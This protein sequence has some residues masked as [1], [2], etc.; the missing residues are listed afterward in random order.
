MASSPAVRCVWWDHARVAPDSSSSPLF[1]ASSPL[2]IEALL[3]NVGKHLAL[4]LYALSPTFNASS[5]TLTIIMTT[6][7]S[8]VSIAQ[9]HTAF[10]HA[11]DPG[12]LTTCTPSQRDELFKTGLLVRDPFD[13]SRFLETPFPSLDRGPQLDGPTPNASS[14]VDSSPCEAR[15][16]GLHLLSIPSPAALG[17]PSSVPSWSGALVGADL[18]F[19]PT[20]TPSC[21]VAAL[22][23]LVG[24]GCL[25][26]R[27]VSVVATDGEVTVVLEH[28]GAGGDERDARLAVAFQLLQGGG[29][30]WSEALRVRALAL[31]LLDGGAA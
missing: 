13:S 9:L 20:S 24:Q 21:I 23:R 22:G 3:R 6:T 1:Q 27:V 19:G 12:F 4:G 30:P 5:S 26:C 14:L 2:P 28:D 29:V 31:G 8:P 7:A 10:K 18:G 25:P 17:S 16:I 15:S 11:V